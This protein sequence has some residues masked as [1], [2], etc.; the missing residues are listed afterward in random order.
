MTWNAD[1]ERFEIDCAMDFVPDIDVEKKTSTTGDLGVYSGITGVTMLLS[2]TRGSSTAIDASLS[3]SAAERSAT[4]G[5]IYAT[6]DV[7]ALQTHLLPLVG[8][9]VWLNV[10]KSGELQYEPF[11]CLV[12]G[13]RLWP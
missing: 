4:A 13:D 7:A 10:Y 2:A 3:Q 9:T 6:F 8:Q 1:Q 5:R 12:K 11:R